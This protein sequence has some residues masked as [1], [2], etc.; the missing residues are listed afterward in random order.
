MDGDTSRDRQHR[1]ATFLFYRLDLCCALPLACFTLFPLCFPCFSDARCLGMLRLSSYTR[2]RCVHV[3]C[4]P[5]SCDGLGRHASSSRPKRCSDLRSPIVSRE[6]TVYR[7]PYALRCLHAAQIS[8]PW[9]YASRL[10]LHWKK[11]RL[12]RTHYQPL[13]TLCIH[14]VRVFRPV[15]RLS[16]CV[17]RSFQMPDAQGWC[18][19]PRTTTSMRS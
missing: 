3:C 6:S 2:P 16:I 12:V 17:S 5:S 9:Y 1:C 18:V 19:G 15:L 7:T 10:I 4:C 14:L 11:R 13:L 8:R